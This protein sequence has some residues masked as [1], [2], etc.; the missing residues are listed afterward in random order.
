MLWQWQNRSMSA[1]PGQSGHALP[2]L[3]PPFCAKN[4]LMH[5]S[6]QHLY[7]IT[8]SASASSVGGGVSPSNLA[9]LRLMM[10][11]NLVG[12][13]TGRWAG[14]SPFRMRSTYSAERRNTSADS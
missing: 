5:R 10:K 9:V 8:S 12:A 1:I 2:D 14:L 3:Q 7:S 6:K 11:L 4:G 13:C